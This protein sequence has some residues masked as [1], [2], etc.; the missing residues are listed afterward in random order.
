MIVCKPMNEIAGQLARPRM[1]LLS[2]GTSVRSANHKAQSRQ[3]WGGS[4]G[5]CKGI[6]RTL[7]PFMRTGQRKLF[8]HGHVLEILVFLLKYISL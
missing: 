6:G 2:L 1:R 8:F 5:M 4:R 7:G 3:P